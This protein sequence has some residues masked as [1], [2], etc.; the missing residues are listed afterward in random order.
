MQYNT[1]MNAHEYA[2][3]AVVLHSGIYGSGRIAP[4]NMFPH[5][6]R[7]IYFGL[8]SQFHGDDDTLMASWR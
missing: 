2:I 5:F 8:S 1:F 4:G 3:H 6:L 7:F